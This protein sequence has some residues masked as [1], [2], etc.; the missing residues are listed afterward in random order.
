MGRKELPL[1]WH[2]LCELASFVQKTL[3]KEMEHMVRP[4]S[5]SL[6]FRVR[7]YPQPALNEKLSHLGAEPLPLPDSLPTIDPEEITKGRLEHLRSQGKPQSNNNGRELPLPPPEEKEQSY[8]PLDRLRQ[9][10]K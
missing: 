6:P 10:T 1:V 3:G 5:H 9:L 8:G 2:P 4:H 7:N